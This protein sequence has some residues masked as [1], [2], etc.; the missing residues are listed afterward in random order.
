[1]A[2]PLLPWN[3]ADRGDYPALLVWRARLD[4]RYL[5]EVQRTDDYHGKLLIFDH[6]REDQEIAHWDVGLSYGAVFGPDTAD[7]QEWEEK[8]TDFID[9][10]YN[11]Q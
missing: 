2:E 5:V 3:A 6:E 10:S 1:M 9:H 11:P 8:V 7:V 4:T